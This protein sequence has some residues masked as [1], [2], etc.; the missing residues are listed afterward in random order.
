M[1]PDQ[2]CSLLVVD[3]EPYI[4]MTLSALLSRE[5]DLVTRN[6]DGTIATILKPYA[7]I[8]YKTSGGHDSYN[9]MQLSLSRRSV[10]GVSMNAQYALGYSKGNTG[11]SN[12]ATTAGKVL[13]HSHP[14]LIDPA[15]KAAAA[16]VISDED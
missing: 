12:E 5:F 1:S 4:L 9:A 15:A 11:G 7:E 16:P 8:D 2:K 10:S 6:A 14:I 13:G 3:D